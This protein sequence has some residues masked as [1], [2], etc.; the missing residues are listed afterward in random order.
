MAEIGSSGVDS[1]LKASHV[2]RTRHAH[3]ISVS[4]LHILQEKVYQQYIDSIQDNEQPLSQDEWRAKRRNESPYFKF[5]DNTIQYE[6]LL[7]LFIKS[8]HGGLFNLYVFDAIQRFVVLM[9]DRTN[10]SETVD[11]ARK[12]LYTKK[13]REIENNYPTK[14]ALLQHTKRAVYQGCHIWC[15]T[16]FVL[17]KQVKPSDWGYEWSTKSN[18]RMSY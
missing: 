10:N 1:F 9:Y 8:L 3:Q 2:G 7:L 13:S 6:T 4:A 17:Q 14:A 18:S 15:Q 12:F 16:L 11:Q 5:L